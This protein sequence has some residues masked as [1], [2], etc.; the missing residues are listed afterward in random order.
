[1]QDS[2]K[3]KSPFHQA[4]HAFQMKNK[5]KPIMHIDI[6]GKFNRLDDYDLDLGIESLNVKW[7]QIDPDFCI[8]FSKVLTDNFNKAL[9]LTKKY[10][11]FDPICNNQ[12][13]LH[14]YWGCENLYTMTE[15]AIDLGIPSFQLEIPN[16]MRQQLYI[17]KNFSNAFLK[18]IVDSYNSV[19]DIWWPARL[20]T[21]VCDEN[22]GKSLVQINEKQSNNN[23][24]VL[25]KKYEKWDSVPAVGKII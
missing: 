21:Q 3:A 25:V 9:S 23:Y 1:M 15:Q 12:P 16:A 17:D 6:H 7:G 2:K 10:K 19:V 20:I 18:A 22:I 8:S 4:L 24:E 5:D 14:G 11:G 13:N